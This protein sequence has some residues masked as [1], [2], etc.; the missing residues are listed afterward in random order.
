MRNWK[1]ISDIYS[2][3]YIEDNRGLYPLQIW[4]NQLIDKTILEITLADVLRM[5]RQDIFVEIAIVKAIDF[6]KEDP[7]AGECY[8][9]ELLKQISEIDEVF[10]KEYIDVLEKI[11]LHA[12][13]ENEMYEWMIEGER[14]EFKSIINFSLE[15]IIKLKS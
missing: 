2:C 10:L 8:D 13:S 5:M 4:Y 14:E 1:K 7:F 9:G 12:L 3:E 11:L 6:L 15:R